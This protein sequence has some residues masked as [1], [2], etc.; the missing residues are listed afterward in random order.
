MARKYTFMSYEKIKKLKYEFLTA[1]LFVLSRIPSLGHDNFNTD[2]WKWKARIY[3]FGSGVFGLDFI[4]T[5]QKYHPGVTLMWIG[6]MAVKVYNFYYELILKTFPTDNNIKTIFELDFVQKLFV[7]VVISLTLASI[8]YVLRNMFGIKYAAFA[9]VLLAAEPFYVALSKVIHLEGLMSTFMIAS[10]A[11]LYFYHTDFNKK[12]LIISALFAALA[13]LTKTSA[14]FL[15]GFT[16]L[17]MSYF[18]FKSKLSL[19][20]SAKNYFQWI[21]VVLIVFSALWP[22]VWVSPLAV[23]DTLYKGIFTIGVEGGH[24]QFYFGKLVQDPGFTYYFVVL[25]LKTSF[26]LLPGIFIYFLLLKKIKDAKLKNFTLY[27]LSFSLLYLLFLTIPSKKLDRYLLPSVLSLS[28][29]ASAGYYYLFQS[30]SKKLRYPAGILLI[31]ALLFSLVRIHP[32]YFSYYNPLFGGLRRGIYVLEPKWLIGQPEISNYLLNLKTQNNLED[33]AQNENIDILIN[34]S[35]LNN[36]LTV[37]FQEKYY[38]Q[39]WPFVRETGGW[40]IISDLTP[41]AVKTSYFIYPVWDDSGS[42]ENRFNI[43]Y[44]DNIKVRGVPVYNVYKKSR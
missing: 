32:D 14:L 2:V 31:I 43:E 6:S 40:A 10:I 33:F 7:V 41:Y 29:V 22:A 25:A 42:A 3:D 38:T 36:K 5:I 20:K 39:I 34:D 19:S 15:V 8:F 21:L 9:L 35:S 12:K 28:L 37:G 26:Y 23:I 18:A 16:A 24:E 27:L 11:W 44:V 1:V 30:L 4:K 17:Y 13:I